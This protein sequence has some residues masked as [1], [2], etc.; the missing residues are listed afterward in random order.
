MIG[1]ARAS[2]LSVTAGR[3]RLSLATADALTPTG[4]VVRPSFFSGLLSRPDAMAAALLAVA[5]V[6]ATSY[7][8]LSARSASLDPVVTASGDRLRFEAFSRCNGVYARFDLLGDGIDAGEVGFGTTNV[9]INPPL[10]QSLASTQLADLLH[11]DVGDEGLAVSTPAQTHL[12]RPVDLPDRWIRG[13]AEVPTIAA[14]MRLVA[15]CARLPT[16]TFLASLPPGAPG[17]TIHYAPGPRGLQPSAIRR[18][19]DVRLAGTSRLSAARRIM[20]FADRMR[21]YGHDSGASGWVFDIPGGRVTFLISAEPYRGFSG[22]GGL[23]RVLS[24]VDDDGLSAV[25]A[26]LSWQPVIDAETISQ[27]AG[28]TRSRADGALAVFAVSGRIGFDLVDGAWFHRE[29]PLDPTRV[30]T[31]HARLTRARELV[32]S[33]QAVLTDGA[34][35]VVADGAVHWVREGGGILHCTCQWHARYGHSRGP[36][37]HELAARL[38]LARQGEGEEG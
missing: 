31:D 6:A 29:L 7:Y 17:P 36:C 8:D 3:A 9:D 26:C 16:M 19:A 1:Y 22:E 32:S 11:L 30:T 24:D 13:F 10:R 34:W 37:T 18:A 35:R 28:L 4:P 2:D 27:E 38:L 21:A 5:D 25:A 14:Q 12:E 15:E 23:L 33:G 20:R